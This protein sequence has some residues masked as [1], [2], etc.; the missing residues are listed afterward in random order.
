VVV[1]LAVAGTGVLIGM[2]VARL[3]PGRGS[4]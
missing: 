1:G 2:L 3:N 4:D